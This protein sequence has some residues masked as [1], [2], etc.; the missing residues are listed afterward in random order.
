MYWN[1]EENKPNVKL[2][3]SVIHAEKAS[4][5]LKDERGGRGEWEGPIGGASRNP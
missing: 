1:F 3:A 4:E 2:K 5:M